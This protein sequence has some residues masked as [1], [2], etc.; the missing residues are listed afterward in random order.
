M[1][2]TLGESFARTARKFPAKIAV[3]DDVGKA[4][5]DQ[6]NR[7]V[8]RWAHVLQ[9]LGL[10]KGRKV[11]TLSNN[12]IR[13]MEVFLGNLKVGIVTVPL[14]SRGTLNDI[15]FQASKTD[16]EMVIFESDFTE[17][18]EGMREKLPEVRH[19]VCMGK[20]PPSFAADYDD[21]LGAA[22]ETEPGVELVEEDEA[23][24]MFTG[25]TTG[26]PKGAVLTH[27]NLLWN[28][29][30]TTTE[31]QTPAPEETT[32]YPMQIYHIAAYSR[33]LGFMY[34]GGRFIAIKN[35]DA[36]KILDIVEKER[37]TFMVGNP[38][39]YRMLL[40]ANRKKRRDTSSM[41][42]W[43]CTQGFLHE[44]LKEDLEKDLWPPGGLYGSYALT[45][46][47]PAVTVLKPW[48]TPREWGSV[49]RAYMP[50]EVRIA[51]P[52]DEDVPVGQEGEILV[53]GPTVFKGYYKEPAETVRTLRGG[54]L[55]TGDLGKYDDL[56]YLYM[57]DR[58][59]DM[60][61]TGGLNVYCREV[62]EVL[63]Y[64]PEIGEAVIIGVPDDKWGEAIRAVVVP[65]KG[66][67]L[68]AES[69]IEHCRQRLASYKKPTSVIFVNELPKGSFGGKV[70]KRVLREKYGK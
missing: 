47:S 10:K 63:S 26:D 5:Y 6:L 11:A 41:R 29:I 3:M 1:E 39:I 4:T 56:G 45:E 64:H 49:G 33:F 38:T 57:V 43:I 51:D 58:L 66:V 15:V 34:A 35:F 12:C 65:K 14:N 28:I 27:K 36:D 55:H 7:R 18:A 42:R 23:V 13:L 69:V 48:D 32:I 20:N 70:L 17:V 60:I 67:N 22:R 46:S 31:N 44:N 53:K 62:E 68:T 37:V 25:G 61:K 2:I 16:C 19:Y 21:L 24:I 40:D 8:N 54:W 30:C 50:L 52:D 59:K 9:G